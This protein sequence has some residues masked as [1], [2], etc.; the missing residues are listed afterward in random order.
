[1]TIETLGTVGLLLQGY[2]LVGAALGL[3]IAYLAFRGYRRN[4]SRP[5][6]FFAIGF[7]IIL[8]LPL[9][10]VALSLVFPWL[11]GPGGQAIIQTFE[12]VGLVCIIYALR[13]DP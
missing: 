3:F 8:G 5:M 13:M 9:P 6:L 4:D 7:G 1:M 10:V 11:S 12:L 2:E